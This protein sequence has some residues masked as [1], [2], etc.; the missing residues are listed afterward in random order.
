[1]TYSK[2]Y[3]VS[4]QRS[5]VNKSRWAENCDCAIVS[6]CCSR[7]VGDGTRVVIDYTR[8]GDNSARVVGNR[9]TVVV[10]G[11]T[12]GIG[13][14]T[15][16]GDVTKEVVGEGSRIGDVTSCVVGNGTAIV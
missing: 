3:G 10:Y 6:N 8:V 15:K 13:Y 1:M 14:C 2:F 9:I 5:I 12:G 16:V 7:V 11:T 4:S